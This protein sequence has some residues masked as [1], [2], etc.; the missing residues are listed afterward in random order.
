MPLSQLHDGID[1]PEYLVRIPWLITRAELYDFIPRMF[2][3]TS[4]GGWPKLRF[5]LL[6]VTADFAFNF[7]SHPE[8][9]LLGVVRSGSDDDPI[10]ELFS[11]AAPVLRDRLGNPPAVDFPDHH[12]MW[13]DDHVWVNHSVS[14]PEER[15]EAKGYRLEMYYHA[16]KPR[17]WVNSKER[18]LI[19]VKRLF[20][21]MPGVKV[22]EVWASPAQTVFGLDVRSRRSLAWL[23]HLAC[24]ANV[25]IQLC[26][27]GYKETNGGLKGDDP[28]SI[29]YRVTIPGQ[30]E[31]ESG[32]FST[33][34]QI[35]GI[36]LVDY[37]LARGLLDND[38]A[39]QL[40]SAFNNHE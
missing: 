39:H 14:V 3:K 13:R 20:K 19:Q 11:Q 17:D 5:T 38:E 18:T 6:G 29:L 12:Q 24:W 32:G 28:S 22:I 30:R 40:T 10:D 36:Y 15:H 33:T 25:N 37:L 4:A 34:F 26:I 31:P 21:S 27:D 16:G 9:R 23:A 8:S 35:V 2:F 7:V 1:V